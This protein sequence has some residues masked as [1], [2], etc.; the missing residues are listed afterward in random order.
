MAAPIKFE[1]DPEFA[2]VKKL[3][4]KIDQCADD[5]LDA[6]EELRLDV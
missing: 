6:L 2:D 3:F 1:S 5:D 4:D